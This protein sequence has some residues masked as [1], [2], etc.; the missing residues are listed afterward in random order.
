VGAARHDGASMAVG[1]IHQRCRGFAQPRLDQRRCAAQTEDR[2]RIDD[3]LAGRAA[4]HVAAGFLSGRAPQLTNEIDRRRARRGDTLPQHGDV[5]VHGCRRGGDGVRCRRG[6]D[7]GGSL[8]ASQRD[9]D[10]DQIGKAAPVAERIRQA[11]VDSEQIGEDRGIQ[12]RDHAS[13]KTV[14]RSPW[15]WMSQR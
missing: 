3:V 14:S 11:I 4:M 8:G 2:R 10:V 12:Q 9:L 7:A 1:E 15:R 6:N 13:K 5:D